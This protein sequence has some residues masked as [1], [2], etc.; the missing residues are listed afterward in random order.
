MPKLAELITHTP[1]EYASKV[2]TLINDLLLLRAIR[3]GLRE[4]V[5][6]SPIM[7]S[8]RFSQHFA[9]ALRG[10]WAE[11]RGRACLR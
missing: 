4:R 5:A 9:Q 10:M 3:Y 8:A 11:N 2:L 1:Q 6:A 7:D